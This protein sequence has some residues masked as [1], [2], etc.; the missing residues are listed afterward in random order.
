[1]SRLWWV[2]HGPT[3]LRTLAPPDAPA[4]LS[5]LAALGRLRAALPLVP[6]VAS[7]LLRA[8]Q[9]ADALQGTRPRLPDDAA[10][11]EFDHGDWTGLTWDRIGMLW[12]DL[13]RAYLERPGKVAPP[14]GE[15][16]DDGAARVSAAADR[17]A[18]QGDHVVVSHMGAIL[19]QIAR[20]ARLT[21]AA[22]LAERVDPLGVTCLE[23]G[24]GGWRVVSIN[25][26]P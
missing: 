10:F 24:P 13:S 15:S 23:Q 19:T 22:V 12:P 20:A 26:R 9:T 3:H 4:D 7:P 21:P 2:R 11:R 18:R 6:V 16:W 25:Q 1:M 14:G 5:D 17:L 8:R